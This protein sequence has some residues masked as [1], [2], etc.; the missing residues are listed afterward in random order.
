MKIISVA[1]TTSKA[2]KTLLAEQI[3]RYC[4]ERYSPVYAV[5]FTTTS[6]LPSPCPR[7][8]PCTVCDLSDL[9]R[10]VRDP[11]IL[12]QKGKNT[13]RFCAAGPTGVLWVIS[14]KSQ[15]SNAYHHL[16]THIPENALVVMEGS[17]I[18]SL[19]EPSLLFY[20]FANHISP[21]RWKESAAE[22][23]ARSDFVLMNRRHKLSD[24]PE[25]KIPEGT[26]CLDLSTTLVTEIPV[27]RDRME[28]VIRSVPDAV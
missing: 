28:A 13:A 17:S 4:A 16:L 19:C 20:V 23:M 24:H 26:L 10:V 9:F 6:D 27:I 7:G 15:L 12:Q 14:K 3:I 5:K 18:T 22:I 21:R 1:G 25:L 2:G 11:E 8:A